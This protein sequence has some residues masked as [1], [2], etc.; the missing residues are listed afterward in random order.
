[1]NDRELT[2][3][4]N[5]LLVII[6]EIDRIFKKNDIRY[7]LIAGSMLGVI[8][9]KGFILWDDEFD[10]GMLRLEYNQFTELCRQ[11]A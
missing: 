11:A 7:S 10:V 3:L 4:H 5:L 6:K 8:R 2:K 9:H 1:M